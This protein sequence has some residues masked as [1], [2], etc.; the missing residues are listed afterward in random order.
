M[1][2]FSEALTSKYIVDGNVM[3]ATPA[4][5]L[6]D[7]MEC[8]AAG[9]LRTEGV[10]QDESFDPNPTPSTFIKSK[11][12]SYIDGIQSLEPKFQVRHPEFA[13]RHAA[14][15]AIIDTLWTD[16][17]FG[18]ENVRISPHWH[19]LDKSGDMAAF[20]R[21]VES[22][23]QYTYD[24]GVKIDSYDI[25]GSDGACTLDITAGVGVDECS[26]EDGEALWYG[27]GRKCPDNVVTGAASRIIYIPFDTC[28]YRLGSSALSGFAGNGSDKAPELQDPDWFM[29]CYEVMRELVEDGIILSGMTVG[30]GGLICAASK[31]CASTG[32]SLDVSSIA[33]SY[34]EENLARIL[35]AEVP[36]VLF[37][38]S[39][40]DLDY[41]DSQ[42]LL[43]DIA[44]YTVGTPEG[45]H[46]QIRV[47]CEPRKPAVAGILQ[48]L[49]ANVSEG[50]D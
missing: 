25:D 45:E 47:K 37:Q 7:C 21:S 28:R 36:G 23:C 10:I 49:L 46:G 14:A 22:L 32:L 40:D 38:V 31:L 35:F 19:W 18:L 2:D 5:L 15:T 3:D 20:Y 4:E 41:I 17:H 1:K 24:L 12:A 48:S 13:V 27:S 29:D 44:Y 26:D 30:K 6:D 33:S 11:I 50:E 43:Q 42:F 8:S 39:T 16:G 9:P 34:A